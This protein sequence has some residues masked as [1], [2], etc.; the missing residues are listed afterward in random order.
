MGPM[1]NISNMKY[2]ANKPDEVKTLIKNL[3]QSITAQFKISKGKPDRV[4]A[5]CAQL[6]KYIK[7]HMTEADIEISRQLLP[8]LLK[9]AGPI[10]IPL[11]S[12][13]EEVAANSHQPWPILNGLLTARDKN[14]VTRALK[15]TVKL[16]ESPAYQAFS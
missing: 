14:L 2:H 13:L 1:K 8:L 10:A 11:F 9:R 3:I 5:D 12:L 7:G 16:A 6:R 15:S 4:E